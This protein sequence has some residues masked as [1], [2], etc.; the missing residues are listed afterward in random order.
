MKL[1]LFRVSAL[2]T[3]LLFAPWAFALEGMITVKVS[4]NGQP[5]RGAYV[6]LVAADEP[7]SKPLHE[8]I[9][10]DTAEVTWRAPTGPYRLVVSAKGYWWE[11]RDAFSLEAGPQ[12]RTEV[13]DLKQLAS[14]DGRVVTS[15][16]A[17]IAGAK[18][19]HIRAFAHSTASLLSTK[20]EDYLRGNWETVSAADGSFSLPA[21]PGHRHS[22]I[23]EAELFEPGLIDNQ[24]VRPEEKRIHEV[25]L[26]I[27]A[28]LTVTWPAGDYDGLVQ[29]KAKQRKFLDALPMVHP[30]AL[31]ERVPVGQGAAWPSLP[32]GAYQLY[33]V[34]PE[35]SGQSPHLLGSFTLEAG[36]RVAKVVEL[37]P[38]T[39]EQEYSAVEATGA[40]SIRLEGEVPQRIERVSAKVLRGQSWLDLAA[41]LERA[42][43]GA[44]LRLPAGAPIGEHVVIE[45]DHLIATSPRIEKGITQLQAKLFPR[46]EVSGTLKAIP[47]EKVPDRILLRALDCPRRGERHSELLTLPARVDA[48]GAFSSYVAEGCACLL[49]EPGNYASLAWHK[50]ASNREKPTNL[51]ARQLFHGGSILARLTGD[52]GS[53][54]PNIQVAAITPA[55][56]EAQG[57]PGLND[58]SIATLAQDQSSEE[59]WVELRHLPA[60][61][62]FLR[63]MPAGASTPILTGPIDV[64]AGEQQVL[65]PWIMTSIAKVN[66][67]LAGEHGPLEDYALILE[68]AA[69]GNQPRQR[70]ETRSNDSGLARFTEIPP[71]AYD[72]RIF[73]QPKG[74][75]S[76]VATKQLQV[77][78]GEELH[79][80]IILGAARYK[81]Q[82]ATSSGDFRHEGQIELFPK[83]GMGTPIRAKIDDNGTFEISLQKPQKLSARISIPGE[84]L[85]LSLQEVDFSDPEETTRILLPEGRLAGTVVGPDGTP[86]EGVS[87]SANRF[88]KE[89][90]V[91]P[92]MLSQSTMSDELGRF[93]LDFLTDGTWTLL[94]QSGSAKSEQIDINL[95]KDENRSDLFIELAALKEQRGRVLAA[96]GQPLGRVRVVVSTDGGRE[97]QETRTGQEGEFTVRVPEDFRGP[98][99]ILVQPPGGPAVLVRRAGEPEW[100][101]MMPSEQGEL[102]LPSGEHTEH[103]TL[104]KPD[105]ASMSWLA[106]ADWDSERR[107]LNVAVG[108]WL[109]Q[110][111]GGSSQLY[112]VR[113]GVAMVANPN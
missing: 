61:S 77:R 101:L 99:N 26:E 37:P 79:Q 64:V 2:L 32:A 4:S 97:M 86:V 66:L 52:D 19:G 76:E 85:R 68:T 16:G 40:L 62:Y 34:G 31:W 72:L 88:L 9:L 108:H 38:R 103:W 27:G 54:I 24:W 30:D 22:A 56:A 70:F 96:S 87:V 100:V 25:R 90:G 106:I 75:R 65:D 5:L 15:T 11:R 73:F 36:A 6:A 91:R 7:W 93:Q 46:A 45:L 84:K 58:D 33:W 44:H 1:G 82:M 48:K 94:A 53:P 102:R 80:K 74:S 89:E 78:S 3:S 35:G 47:G 59:G 63:L 13:L 98:M 21:L 95:G 20:G 18:V 112:E 23:V 105:G 60:G 39:S 10:A 12:P 111:Q 8:E 14:L 17:P 43:G 51:G 113:P 71:G 107:S 69:G 41:T 109:L 104:S 57:R 42:S 110:R 49:V 28:S 92:I 29:L 50:V 81:A 67:Q 55:E 83:E